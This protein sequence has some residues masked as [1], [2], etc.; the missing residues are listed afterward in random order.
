MAEKFSLCDE[1]NITKGFCLSEERP[2]PC[3]ISNE[4]CAV[5]SNSVHLH[6]G[7]ALNLPRTHLNFVRLLYTLSVCVSLH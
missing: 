1:E 5:F 7:T 3:V 4:K 2:A 6:H